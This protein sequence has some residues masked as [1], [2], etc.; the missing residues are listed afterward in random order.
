[1]EKSLFIFL[2]IINFNCFEEIRKPDYIQ[3][4]SITNVSEI[5]MRI[6][7]KEVVGNTREHFP[8]YVTLNE[9][10]I[11]INVQKNN[12]IAQE[13]TTLILECFYPNDMVEKIIVNLN[14]VEWISRTNFNFYF[15]L[16]I[17]KSNWIHFCISTTKEISEQSE[18]ERFVSYGLKKYIHLDL[19]ND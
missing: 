15:P 18:R 9:Y 5:D 7:K 8:G 2:I 14:T 16:I 12:Y 4:Y 6:I 1:M 17:E 3:R 10:L 13:D 11:K 19:K